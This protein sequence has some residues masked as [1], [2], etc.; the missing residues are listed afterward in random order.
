MTRYAPIAFLCL[1]TAISALWAVTKNYSEFSTHEIATYS[2]YIALVLIVQVLCVL[3]VRLR[4]ARWPLM[5]MAAAI[6]AALFAAFNF[7]TIILIHNGR[8]ME[9]PGLIFYPMLA[10]YAAMF[11][12]VFAVRKAEFIR[13]GY[14]FLIILSV[15]IAGHFTLEQITSVNSVIKSIPSHFTKV[16]FKDKPN[17]YVLTF[18][19]LS[20]PYTVRELLNLKE[21]AAYEKPIRDFGGRPLQNLFAE[22][23]PTKHS[24]GSFLAMDI[25][26]YDGTRRKGD[27]VRNET[28][29]PAYEILKKNGYKTQF[30][31][32]TSYFGTV[33]HLD[34]YG[35]AHVNG[36]CEHIQSPYAFAGFCLE[37]VQDK[38]GTLTREHKRDYI[39]FLSE[40]IEHAAGSDQ[41]WFTF[42]HI[43]QPGHAKL[44]FD[45]TK[46]EDWE[47]FRPSFVKRSHMAADSM[48]TLLGKIREL[49]PDA[50]ILIFG[51]HGPLITYAM[52]KGHGTVPATSPEGVTFSEKEIKQDMHAVRGAVFSR[53]Y[54]RDGFDQN[55]YSTTRLM[56]DVMICLSHGQ[57]PL[58]ADYQPDDSQW[59]DYVYE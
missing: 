31:Y 28:P 52:D 24:L 10:V 18:D 33:K 34:Y 58:P 49:D 43:Y 32:Q 14:I 46:A 40:R 30:L 1:I 3:L 53:T 9:L 44:T 59:A 54:C 17:I 23:I 38:V 21:P 41:P 27:F 12:G 37:S 2:L 8:I 29:T 35:V 7:F 47:E 56:R 50:I 51:D 36:L 20:P 16:E 42:A 6:L 4:G 19:T 48:T 39:A 5:D 26:Y 22:R 15:S 57:D 25:A 11:I 45:V 13:F 55:P